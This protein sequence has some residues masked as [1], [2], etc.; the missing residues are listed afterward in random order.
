MF[1]VLYLSKASIET[2]S[3]IK[4]VDEFFSCLLPFFRVSFEMG[5]NAGGVNDRPEDMAFP[6]IRAV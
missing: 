1:A 6:A 3:L 4:N 5:L 2:L